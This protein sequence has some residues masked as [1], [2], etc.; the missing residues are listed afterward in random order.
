M[1]VDFE[2]WLYGSRARG[3]A[4]HLS[5]TDLLVVA[6]H[7]EA[8]AHAVRGLTF[9]RINVSFYSW[10]E[11]EAMR[12]YGSLYLHHVATEGRRLRAS[13]SYPERL[14]LLLGAVPS[15]SRARHDLTGFQ[16]ALTEGTQ[17]L[18]HG[19]WPDFECGVI[20]TVIR[21]AAILGAYCAGTPAFGRERPFEAVGIALGYS[22]RDIAA[23]VGPATAWRKHLPGPHA[24]PA[25]TD[26]WLS[27]AARFLE[28][29]EEVINDYSSVL[30][31]AA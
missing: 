5:D 15:F 28:D 24:T 20:A 14:P 7:S 1:T 29:L 2:L 18:R 8:V 25:A 21:H 30:P 22:P 23:L 6:D 4:D 11:V 12:D 3:D 27:R 31:Q 26:D 13:V 16:R 19:G 9:P 10:D 17:S